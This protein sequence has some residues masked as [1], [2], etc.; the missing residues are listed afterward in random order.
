MPSRSSFL[1]YAG[2][3][4]ASAVTG[5]SVGSASL[6]RLLGDVG[7]AHG[8]GPG[9]GSDHGADRPVEN[10]LGAKALFQGGLHRL[11]GLGRA[12]MD[13]GDAVGAA[14]GLDVLDHLLAGLAPG[15]GRR[16]PFELAVDQQQHRLDAEQAA[17]G[18]LEAIRASAHDDIF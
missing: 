1:A 4:P 10:V 17:D 9:V 3:T 13:D 8:A 15:P 11:P 12:S 14:V 18:A 16:H 2:V 5:A 7:D 6:A